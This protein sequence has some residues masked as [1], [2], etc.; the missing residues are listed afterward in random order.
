MQSLTISALS[1]NSEPSSW[2][3]RQHNYNYRVKQESPTKLTTSSSDN[4]L[5]KPDH[6]GRSYNKEYDFPNKEHVKK[7]Q[8][9]LAA[10]ET[11][12]SWKSKTKKVGLWLSPKKGNTN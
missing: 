7:S 1:A 12:E 11:E 10:T 4:K 2:L 8:E 3:A 9:N 6:Y 5:K